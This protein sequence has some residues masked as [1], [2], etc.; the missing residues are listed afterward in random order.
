M[1]PVIQVGD[2]VN[3]SLAGAKGSLLAVHEVLN[4]PS[5]GSDYWEFESP[6]GD[7]VAVSNPITVVKVS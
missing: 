3:V 6:S 7:L 2:I 5:V 1:P 4:L